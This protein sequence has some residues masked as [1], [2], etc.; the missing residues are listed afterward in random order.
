MISCY[1]LPSPTWAVRPGVI[2]ASREG[3]HSRVR[4]QKRQ[5]LGVGVEKAQLQASDKKD[6]EDYLIH[7]SQFFFS[8]PRKIKIPLAG[9][10]EVILRQSPGVRSHVVPR[11]LH[12]S[13]TPS[14]G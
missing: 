7:L 5:I 4:E 13:I 10:Q 6:L 11:E 9:I 3:C 12:G 8:C 1:P 14:S 2:L